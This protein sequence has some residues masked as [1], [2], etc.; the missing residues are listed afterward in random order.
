MGVFPVL[1]CLSQLYILSIKHTYRCGWTG[2]LF[3]FSVFNFD[4]EK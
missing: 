2:E 3:L 1:V 4:E